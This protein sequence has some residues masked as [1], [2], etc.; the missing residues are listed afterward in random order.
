MGLPMNGRNFKNMTVLRPGIVQP[1]GQG[2]QFPGISANGTRNED[3]GYLI[4]G[5][6]ADETYTGSSAVNSPTPLGD[7]PTTLPFDAIQEVNNEENPKADVGWKPGAVINI[8]LKSGTNS[9]H[10][11]AFAYGRGDAFDARNYFDAPPLPKTPFSLEQFG[12][13][14]GG[15]IKKDKLFWFLRHLQPFASPDPLHSILPHLPPRTLQQHRDAPVAVPPILSR[16]GQDR[17]CQ[18]IF[19]RAP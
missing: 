19:V 17:L 7:G 11:T 8:G 2:E 16:Q 4:D 13:S 5:L 14:A 18:L 1:P 9:L 15:P 10:G 6:R 3:V 12:A